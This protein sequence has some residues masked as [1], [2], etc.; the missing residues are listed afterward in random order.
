MFGVESIVGWIIF[1]WVVIVI[2]ILKRK[3]GMNN[4]YLSVV[5]SYEL[6]IWVL[7]LGVK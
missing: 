5:E 7:V 6:V 3:F 4:Y 1:N 2:K